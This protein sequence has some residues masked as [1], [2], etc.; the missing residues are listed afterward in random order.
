MQM[1]NKESIRNRLYVKLAFIKI[2]YE[3]ILFLF[4]LMCLFTIAS[5]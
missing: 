1:T 5:L 3:I 2:Q 4:I